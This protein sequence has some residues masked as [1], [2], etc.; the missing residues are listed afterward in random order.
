M[1]RQGLRGVMSGK[2]MRTTISDDKG[3][4]PLDRLNRQFRVERP[5]QL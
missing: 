1:R 3:L 4:Y 2:V 5:N